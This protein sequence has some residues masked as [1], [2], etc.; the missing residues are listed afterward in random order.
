LSNKLNVLLPIHD[1]TVSVLELLPELELWAYWS[2]QLAAYMTAINPAV[3]CH[4]L[5][6]GPLL[7]FKLQIII[8]F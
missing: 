1:A 3:G 6:Q 8:T 2:W 4:Y 7:S 5:P